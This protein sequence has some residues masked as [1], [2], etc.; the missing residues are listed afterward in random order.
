MFAELGQLYANWG[1]WELE[2]RNDNNELWDDNIQLEIC[3]LNEIFLSLII[4][5]FE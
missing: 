2:L 1:C 4:T 5:K 3:I